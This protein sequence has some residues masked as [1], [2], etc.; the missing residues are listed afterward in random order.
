MTNEND[1]D[2]NPTE[3]GAHQWRWLV[4]TLA[5][6]GAAICGIGYAMAASTD[7]AGRPGESPATQALWFTFLIAFLGATALSI[8]ACLLWSIRD[9]LVEIRNLYASRKA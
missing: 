4:L 5:I 9:R 2:T 7:N 8:V 6:V 1:P 3:W